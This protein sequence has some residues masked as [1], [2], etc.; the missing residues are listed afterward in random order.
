M[1]KITRLLADLV[2]IDSINPDLVPGGAGEGVI[3]QFIADWLADAGLEVHLDEVKPGR[4][5]VIAIARGKGGGKTLILNGHID[6]VG[7]AGITNP[8]Q[9][10]IEGDRMYGRGALDMKCGLAACMTAMA[11][12]QKLEL[13]G[14]V[15]FTAVM[16]EEF[17]GLGTVDVA[18]KYRADAAI[19]AEPT[20]MELVVAHKGFVWLE[21][22]THGVAAHGSLSQ[23]GV[24]AI[25]KM[26]HVLVELDGLNERLLANPT[27]PLLKSGSLHASLINGG[28]ELSSYPER[29]V[30][31]VERRTIPGETTEVVEAQV[32]DIV[33][34][35]A[36]SD[37]H[38]KATV[39]RNLDRAPMEAPE[40]LPIATLIQQH[41][42]QVTGQAIKVTGMA[43]WTDAASLSEV[44]I[45]SVLFGPTGAGAHA[46]EE[47]VDL[48]S[49]QH[50]AA[51]YLRV[52]E[53][54]CQ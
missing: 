13:R 32:N 16:D 49:V 27:H 20:D 46:V 39:R 44:G 22:E 5:N 53:A 50:C 41:A 42:A 14:D 29:C 28:Q 19:V 6:T 48:P 12:A 34:R 25:T 7:V 3:A 35:L 11:E 4:P 43:G 45:P 26:G 47:W 31:A 33:Q 21:I 15:M 54:F 37:P 24:D 9:P 40:D 36:A 10:I 30:L 18:T 2:A 1:D 8:H 51:I 23:V 52:I 17:A 38:F